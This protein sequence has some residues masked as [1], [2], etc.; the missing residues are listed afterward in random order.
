MKAFTPT[1]IQRSGSDLYNE[2]QASGAAKINH[3]GR[4]EM[5]VLSTELLDKLLSSKTQ[6]EVFKE[7]HA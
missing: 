6:R 3:K 7:L 1:Q 5:V 4:P 2:V